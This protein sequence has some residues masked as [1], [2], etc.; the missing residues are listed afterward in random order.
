MMAGC[1]ALDMDCAEIC[2]VAAAYMA[3]GSEFEKDLCRLCRY[4]S[5][6][7]R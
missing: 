5:D 7:R 1:I 2:R 6:L 4:L 3:R